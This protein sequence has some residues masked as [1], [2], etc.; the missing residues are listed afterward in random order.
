MESKEKKTRVAGNLITIVSKAGQPKRLSLFLLRTWCAE[1]GVD[2][3]RYNRTII[4]IAYRSYS[5]AEGGLLLE[6][7]IA[8]DLWCDVPKWIAEKYKYVLD[9]ALYKD[10]DR[11][12]VVAEGARALVIRNNVR[13]DRDLLADLPDLRIIGRLGVGLDNIDLQ[14]CRERNV[15]VAAAKGYNANAVVEYVIAGIFHHA[16]FLG[17]CD[18]YTKLAGWDRLKCMGNEVSGKTLGLIGVGDI[19]QRLAVRAR[20]LGL[21]V[22]AHDPFLL[23]SHMI[24]Q[25]FQ[26]RLASLQEV[27]RQSDY[28]SIHTPLTPQTYHMIGQTEFS[29]MK[30]NAVLINTARGGLID[31]GALLAILKQFPNR[32]A[33][34]DV[35]EKEPPEKEDPFCL[36]PNVLLTPHIAGITHESVQRVTE[37]V[38]ADV[39]RVLSCQKAIGEV[40]SHS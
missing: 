21:N 34:L 40:I 26:V 20:A 37:F 9:P 38:L 4:F 17:Q 19:G 15:V 18:S 8:E 13:V 11:L 12:K 33:I 35:R 36:L 24:V 2:K 16:R 3:S 32:F 14:A 31:E 1:C 25:D 5:K 23:D 6:I 27:C 10:R 30:E 22:I 39:D 28:I 7:V 29:K